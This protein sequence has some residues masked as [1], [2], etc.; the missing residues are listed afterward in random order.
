M[1]QNERITELPIYHGRD[2][3]LD[4]SQVFDILRQY[5]SPHS[6]QSVAYTTQMS[7]T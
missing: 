7:T 6:N 1:L 3:P 5:N 4:Q 2:G